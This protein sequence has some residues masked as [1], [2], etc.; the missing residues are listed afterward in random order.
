VDVGRASD[1]IAPRISGNPEVVPG[2]VGLWE[3]IAIAPDT[4]SRSYLLCSRNRA[5][6]APKFIEVRSV[7]HTIN[8]STLPCCPPELCWV[9]AASCRD[10]SKSFASRGTKAAHVI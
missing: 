10:R 5:Q 1:S 4:Q 8:Y 7:N 6:T 3:A 2:E 9:A